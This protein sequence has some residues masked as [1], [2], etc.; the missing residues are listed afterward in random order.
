ML[1]TKLDPQNLLQEIM[2]SRSQTFGDSKY[3]SLGITWEYKLR[4]Q[5]KMS[6]Q[7]R[8]RNLHPKTYKK[9]NNKPH[10]FWN[11]K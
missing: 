10:V 7:I 3:D 2:Y 5:K 9:C 4:K 8:K 6:T 11:I 1:K